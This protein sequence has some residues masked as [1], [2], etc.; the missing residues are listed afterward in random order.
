MSLF[1][2]EAHT[3]LILCRN[4]YSV[5]QVITAC[6]LILCV[7]L[8]SENHILCEHIYAQHSSLFIFAEHSS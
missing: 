1:F 2:E 6:V 3:L 4:L 5:S 7:F 8:V